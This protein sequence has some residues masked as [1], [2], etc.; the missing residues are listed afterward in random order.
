MTLEIA[1]VFLLVLATILLF[2]AEKFPVDLVALMVMA[3]LLVSQII[4]PEEGISGF[5]NTATVT[6]AAMFVISAGLFKTGALKIIGLY[7]E[8]IARHSYWVALIAMMLAVGIISAFVNNTA[9]VAI[10]MPMLLNVAREAKVSPSKFLM[11][12]SF[13]SMFG[14]TCTLIGTSTNILVNSIAE[15]DGIPS[16]GMFEFFPAVIVFVYAVWAHP[17]RLYRGDRLHGAFGRS[18]HP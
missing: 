18:P 10:F 13:A 14:G 6:V 15:R 1:F 12:L 17:P 7:L 4:T 5:S 2:I 3:S 16:F 9:T 8:R 11:P